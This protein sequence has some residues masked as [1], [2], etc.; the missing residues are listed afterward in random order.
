MRVLGENIQCII[1]AGD[2]PLS[3]VL[4]E[5]CRH[6]G[7]KEGK[8]RGEEQNLPHLLLAVFNSSQFLKG[9]LSSFFL[10][11]LDELENATEIFFFFV[12]IED[13]IETFE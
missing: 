2:K 4:F 11:L 9:T 1:N 6:P 13:S 7:E 8:R 10:C 5:C 12:F 3:K